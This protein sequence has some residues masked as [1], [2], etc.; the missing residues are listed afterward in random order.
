MKF[1]DPRSWFRLTLLDRYI[2][3]FIL[4]G[5][6][7]TLLALVAVF[8]FI[9]FAGEVGDIGRGTY[10]L[11]TAL[12]YTTLGV[13][14]LI[15]ELLPLASLIGALYALGH[16]AAGSELTV[17]RSTGLSVP[18]LV[19]S[20]L[21]T[22]L[23]LFAAA[24]VVGEWVMPWAEKQASNVRSE[25]LLEVT[26]DVTESGIWLRDGNEF[27]RIRKI[28][29]DRKLGNIQV[30]R[31]AENHEPN[32]LQIVKEA[33]FVD[34]QAG[35]SGWELRNIDELRFTEDKAER[36]HKDAERSKSQ[37]QPQHVQLLAVQPEELTTVDLYRYIDFLER[38]GQ[39]SQHHRQV[40]L[41]RFAQPISVLIMLVLAVPFVTRSSRSVPVGHRIFIG[42]MIGIV[43]YLFDKTF[44]HMGLVY[45]FHPVFS[46]FTIPA[47]FLLIG[48][49]LG[50][51]R[52][53]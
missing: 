36:A 5:V 29:N 7:V 51:R 42:V 53:A 16:L 41:E 4:L 34:A 2:G 25:A 15:Y 3:H 14:N 47:I 28:M 30:Y 8:F 31:Y 46:A 38:S 26:Y 20:V 12:L 18:R 52:A 45:Q 22:G 24:A 1:V 44:D 40:F 21:R 37:V 48:V 9:N 32:V 17:M 39:D 23:L 6:G 10:G 50:L 43:F 13:P 11:G 19:M 35:I 27:V 49:G 33:D